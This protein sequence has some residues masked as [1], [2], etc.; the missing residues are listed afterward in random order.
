MNAARSAVT[1]LVNTSDGFE[2]CWPPFFELFKH[3]WPDCPHPIL[4]N[5]ERKTFSYPGLDIQSSRVSAEQDRRLTWSECLLKGLE[6][7]ETPLVLYL[8]EDYFLDKP[9][10]QSFVATC[11]KTM[12]ASPEIA[13]IG[14]TKHGSLGPHEPSEIPALQRISRGARYRIST[15]AGLWRREILA[16]YLDPDESGWMFEIYGT[17]RAR[18]RDDLFLTVDVQTNL[19]PIDY[20]HTG[21]IKGQW[22]PDMP[23]LFSVHGIEMDF[24]RRGFY[25]PPSPLLR[26]WGVLQKLLQ[27]P[28][29]ALRQVFA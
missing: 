27:R 29:H 1:I 11:V 16:S 19:P 10:D 22:H 15:Q 13:H 4:L 12:L 9:V 2:D 5:T 25:Q 24:D 7:V 26:K 23:R 3:Y 28:G 20:V 8:Q 6:Q 18:R 14:L 17:L 21:I